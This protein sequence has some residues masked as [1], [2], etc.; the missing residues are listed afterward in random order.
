MPPSAPPTTAILFPNSPATQDQTPKPD[1]LRGT[2]TL[3]FPYRLLTAFASPLP[4]I[5]HPL[6]LPLSPSPS[7]V[8]FL[9]LLILLSRPCPLSQ[10]RQITKAQAHP[11]DKSFPSLG[12]P[13][14]FCIVM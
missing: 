7:P 13:G 6:P 12:G 5:S 8:S 3:L 10:E 14:A 2:F 4:S 11:A 1:E 9:S